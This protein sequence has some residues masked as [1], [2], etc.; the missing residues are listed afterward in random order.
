METLPTRDPQVRKAVRNA[1]LSA[2]I[3]TA[4]EWYDYYLYA[5]AAGTI[6]NKLFFP[7]FDSLTGTLLAYTTFAIGFFVRPLGSVIFGLLGDRL[8]RKAVLITT[9]MGGTSSTTAT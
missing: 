8:G 6:F 2:I 9:L 4:V 7:S 3:G 5:T 1:T